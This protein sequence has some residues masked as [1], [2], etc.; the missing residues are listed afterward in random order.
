MTDRA[1]EEI[2]AALE[3]RY[4]VEE[5]IG[6]GGMA[7]VYHALD[8]E[9]DREVAI[10]VL[11]PELA[12]SV[13]ARRFHLEVEILKEL[14]HPGI[15]PLYDSGESNQLLYFVMPFARGESL[16]LST[17]F[18]GRERKGVTLLSLAAWMRWPYHE[19]AAATMKV[20]GW[21]ADD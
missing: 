6:R 9:G 14:D 20:A 7:T 10:K 13:M 17:R 12:F 4:R 19:F 11:R 16:R 18:M 5:M 1:L 21:R 15:L 3:G 2:R 8:L